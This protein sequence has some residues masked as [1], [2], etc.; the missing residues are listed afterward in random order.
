V[1]LRELLRSGEYH[2]Y[3]YSYP[4]KTAYRTL[5]SPVSLRELW[6]SED[7]TALFL[8]LHVPFCE[9]R[10]GFCNLFTQVQPQK[11]VESRYL[12]SLELQAAVM[13]E[14][15][16]PHR[17]V[18]LAIGGGTPTFLSAPHLDRL[19]GVARTLAADQ[20]P[21]SI[22]VSPSTLSDDKIALLRAHRVSRVSMGV[23]SI[24]AN[25]T[26]G[27]QRRQRQKEVEQALIALSSA[28]AIRNVDLIYGLPGQ[29]SQTL[30][31]S[32]ERVI[33][34]GANELYLYPLYVRP[35]TI[36]SRHHAHSDERIGLYRDARDYLLGRGF[37]QVSM[38][39][40]TAA[41][42]PGDGTSAPTYRCQDDGM[43]G[44]G[45]GAR[46]YT[47]SLHYA[48]PFAV[49]QAAIRERIA[50]WISASAEDHAQARHGF[51]LSDAEQRRRYLILSLLDGRL[52]RK[53]YINRFGN[54]VCDHFPELAEAVTE[55]LV[56]ADSGSL[57]LTPHGLECADVL[58]HWLQ[59]ESVLS[60]R[61]TWEAA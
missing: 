40:F 47:R 48:T 44:L 42:H 17:F 26:A 51:F 28:V 18:R 21:T 24:F 6:S 61:A 49:A 45:P 2:S 23:Q 15:L 20:V 35:L 41:N 22:E 30:R 5:P 3:A 16:S 56:F 46:S 1:S 37:R 55:G 14:V 36:L 34:L 33:E 31:A 60:A 12:D 52:D 54:D 7:R 25:E 50:S 32:I 27:V 19:F 53:S 43:V 4:H 13:R 57:Q 10:C 38:R 39:M 58:G 11:E 9:Q 29:T 59:S 8:Y